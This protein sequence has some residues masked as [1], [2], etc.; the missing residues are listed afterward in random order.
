MD[1]GHMGFIAIS[2]RTN[3]GVSKTIFT[4]P[5]NFLQVLG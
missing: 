1:Q 4:F 5:Q 3:F 2:E